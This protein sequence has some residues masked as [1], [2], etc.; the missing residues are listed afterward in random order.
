M[1]REPNDMDDAPNLEF[2]AWQEEQGYLE[3][4]DEDLDSKHIPC[5]EEESD[6]FEAGTFGM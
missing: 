3:S 6:Q 4:R 5:T 1:C 2:E